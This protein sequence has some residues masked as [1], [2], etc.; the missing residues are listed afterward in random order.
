[1]RHKMIKL[2]AVEN[3]KRAVAVRRTLA[4][5]TTLVPSFAVSLSERRLDK[6]VPA[7]IIT[8]I[9][10]IYEIGTL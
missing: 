8:E 6:I 1:M 9:I 3:P 4:V 2:F 5:V 10:P 7:E